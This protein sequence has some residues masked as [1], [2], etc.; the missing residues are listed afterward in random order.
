MG[1][2][3]PNGLMRHTLPRPD[4][5]VV[6]DTVLDIGAGLRPMQWYQPKLLHCCVE[7]Y[8][9]Y[10]EK[11]RAAGYEVFEY[12]ALAWLRGCRHYEAVYLLDVIEHMIHLDALNVLRHACRVAQKQVVVFTPYG[13]VQQTHDAWNMGGEYWQT[14]RS[15]WTPEDFPPP[16]RTQLYCPT[17]SQPEGFFALWTR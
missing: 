7:P 11:L 14:H 13:F 3:L 1:K 10:A 15:G 2:P 12:T 4:G 16:W 9:P 5:L 17:T 8:R 6:A